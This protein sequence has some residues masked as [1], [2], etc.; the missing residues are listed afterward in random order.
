MGKE[1][2][3]LLA[4]DHNVLRQGMAQLFAMQPDMM[5]VAQASTGVEAVTLAVQHRPDIILMDINMPEMDGVAATAKI[6]TVLPNTGIIILTM[7]RHD[8]YIFQAI[9]A[10]ANGYLL[11]EVELGELLEAVRTVYRGE[12]VMHPAIASR[13]L[14]SFRESIIPTQPDLTER[15]NTILRLLAQGMGNQAIANN[16]DISEKTV[17]NR[18][19]LIYRKLHIQNRTQATLYAVRK[20]LTD[21]DEGET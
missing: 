6:K 3:L 1:L 15:D 10:G 9:K 11:K 19:S 16:L 13:V 7:Y 18:L 4:D 2:R 8:D 12:A 21:L 14:I 5:V 17:R 20:G